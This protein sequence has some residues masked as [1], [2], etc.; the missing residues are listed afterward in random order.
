[1]RIISLTKLLSGLLLAIILAFMAVVMF[2]SATE[3]NTDLE[4]A[5]M[6]GNEEIL[7][8]GKYLVTAGNCAACHTSP[9]DNEMAGGVAFATQFGTIYSTNI[10]PDADAGIG[11]WSFEDFLTSMRHG[12]RP[13]GQHLYPAFP[14]TAFTKLTDSDIA[15]IFLYLMSLTP[16]NQA[17]PNNE[18]GFPFNQRWLM[19]IWKELYFE[20]GIYEPDESNSEDWNRG[21]Y[22]VEALAHCSACHSPRNFLGAEEADLA[23]SGG[24][25]LDEVPGGAIHDWFAPNLRSNDAGLGSWT[26]EQLTDYL[27]TGKNSLVET[28]GPMNEVIMKSTRHLDIEDVE[29]MAIYLKSLPPVEESSREVAGNL[30]MG[31]GRTVYNLHCGTCHLPTGL[32]DN[33]MGPRLAS[34]SLVVL[35]ENPASLINVI[36]Y[37]PERSELPN[38]WYDKMGEFQYLLD[39]DEIAAVATFVR[40]SWENPGG[41]VTAE[42]V[43]RHR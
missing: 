41:I 26:H 33:E 36:L 19:T 37:G 11:N 35:A 42:D 32:G 2:G 6:S 13:N 38:N 17:A 22:L 43:A 15:A 29:A 30:T 25:Y 40:Q 39:D 14:Y 12:V 27:K 23:M 7:E 9:G 8:L 5:E 24:V 28:F 1:M 18:L 20:S 16:V 21:A 10:T 31:R 3:V 4:I 34:G